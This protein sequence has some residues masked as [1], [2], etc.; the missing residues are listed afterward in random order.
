MDFAQAS[1]RRPSLR[2]AL[3]LDAAFEFVAGAALLVFATTLG[4]WLHIGTLASAVAG[5]VF[6]VAGA[7]IASLL[8]TSRAN[9][10]VVR[11]LALANTVGGCAGWIVAIAAW[12]SLDPAGRGVLGTA[13]DLF[14]V[15]G[16]LELLALRDS[17][18]RRTN[19]E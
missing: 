14:L 13:S 19:A 15:I 17:A 12:S 3:V 2:T 7:F 8:R 11:A 10:S 1:S 18:D 16:V 4:G 6:L 5:V 9:S